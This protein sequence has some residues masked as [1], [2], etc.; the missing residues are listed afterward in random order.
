MKEYRFRDEPP[1][2]KLTALVSLLSSDALARICWHRGLTSPQLVEEFLSNDKLLAISE[3]HDLDR[4]SKTIQ[5]HV[6]NKSK[7]VVYGDYDAD[8]AVAAAIL[9]R[10]LSQI[11]KADATVYIP[12]RHEEGYG[13]NA[14]ALEKLASDGV[15]LVI[16]VDCGVRD[17]E[18]IQ[19]ITSSTKMEIIVTDHHQPGEN[20]P[21][22][23]TIHPL[24]PQHESK[25]PLTSGGV[26]VWKLVRYL[27][28]KLSLGHDF[29]DGVVDLAGTSLVTDIMPLV[30][31]NRVILKRALRKMR[32]SPTLGLRMLAEVAQVPLAELSAYHLGYVIGPRL[33]ASGRIGN[34]Y[35][36]VRLLSTDSID[37]ARRYSLEAN[38]I[39]NTRQEMTKQLLAEADASK[40]IVAEKLIITAGDNWEDGIIGLVAGKLMNKMNLPTITISIDSAKGVAKGSARSFGEFD[41]TK[42][43]SGISSSFERFG[44]HQNAAGFTLKGIDT[45]EFSKTVTR[46][47]EMNYA[48][49]TP[50]SIGYIDAEVTLG[51]L[52]EAFFEQLQQFE[53]FGPGNPQ[54]L[55]ALRGKIAQFST[56][57]KQQNHLRIEIATPEGNVTAMAFDG[58]SYLSRLEQGAEVT[59]VGRPKLNEFKG[60]KEVAFYVEDLL[61]NSER[62]ITGS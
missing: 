36:S 35:T 6:R 12:D 7:I 16:T 22:C 26:V 44:G 8:G 52:S 38:E 14:A 49:Y 28:E 31:E 45:Q 39:N 58:L 41:I 43:F 29:S 3:L 54:P 24:F 18:L 62:Q 48:E 56:V 23:P 9:W 59:V 47:I 61:T 42:F 37:S 32:V 30:G 34:Q 27:E 5:T 11:V 25:N 50:I 20:F 53:P 17:A 21:E 40:Q 13:L 33:N 15:G 46:E 57:G 1:K 55:F 19:K 10:F 2:S 4:V 51:E 60:R